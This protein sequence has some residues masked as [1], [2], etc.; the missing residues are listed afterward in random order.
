[1]QSLAR[2]V[3]LSRHNSLVLGFQGSPGADAIVVM[4]CIGIDVERPDASSLPHGHANQMP[5]AFAPPF[6]D[7]IR[8]S[9]GALETS[10]AGDRFVVFVP[11]SRRDRLL[12]ADVDRK[13]W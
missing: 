5:S 9:C 3:V 8:I 11:Q 6:A 12:V 10:S 2:G 1:M 7:L 13:H 4:I